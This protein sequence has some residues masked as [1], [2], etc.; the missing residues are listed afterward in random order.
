MRRREFIAGLLLIAGIQLAERQRALSGKVYRMAVVDPVV[1]T[2]QQTETLSP[3]FQELRRLNY[4]DGQNLLIERFSGEGRAERFP[5]L[6]RDVVNRNPDLIFAIG[7]RLVLDFKA[8]TATIPIVGFMGDPVAVGIVPSLARPGGNI[9]GVAT[10][11]SAEIEAKR[12]EIL[13]ESVPTIVKVATLASAKMMESPR[14]VPMREA[15][16]KIGI[17]FFSQPLN[18]PFDEAEYRRVFAS[19]ADEG[20]DAVMILDQSENFANRR[21][22]VEL[23]KKRP[24]PAIYPYPDCVRFGGLMAY[25]I[26]WSEVQRHSAVIIDKILKGMK[27]GDIPIYLPSK[28]GLGINLKAASSL[29]LTMPSSLLARADEIV[30]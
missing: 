14:L 25:S 27:P 30:E 21:L 1:P 9:T 5:E 2:A 10:D 22:I 23:L 7:Y 12:L 8:A 20:V 18:P 26:D 4:V 13:K 3:F 15:A 11:A 6:A 28:F 16:R 29:G 17:S 19:I 24:L